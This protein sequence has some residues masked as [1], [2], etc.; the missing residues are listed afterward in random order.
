MSE[1]YLHGYSAAE[2]RRLTRMQDILNETEL[3]ALD[4]E[5]VGSVLDVGAGLG[6]MTRTLARALRSRERVVGVERDARQ[7]AAAEQQAAEA[8]ET[9]LV[10]FRAGEATSLPLRPDERE[11]FDLVHARFLL[12]HVRDPLEVV[13]EMVAAVRPGGRVVLVDDDHELLQTWPA[14]PEVARVWRIYWES[15]RDRGLDPLVGRRLAELLSQAGARPTRVTSL[16][17]GACRGMGAFDLVVDNLIGVL[18]SA[19]ESLDHSGRLARAEMSSATTVLDKWRAGES[20][21]VWYSLPLAEGL[22]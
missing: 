6:Q 13:K 4:L 12:E 10:E 1:E 16:F 21:T 3:H 17:F 5:G 11:S 2:M 19:A 18:E 22:K 9:G 14:C 15:Y 7:R 20:A 8:G